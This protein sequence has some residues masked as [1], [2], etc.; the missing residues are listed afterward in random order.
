MARE[1]AADTDP[2]PE[3]EIHGSGLFFGSVGLLA[4]VAAIACASVGQV[5]FATIAAGYAGWSGFRLWI[6]PARVRVTTEGIVDE[7]FWYSP[8]LIRW[9][10]I[11]DVRETRWPRVD[12]VLGVGG[13]SV[14]HRGRASGRP[15]HVRVDILHGSRGPRTSLATRHRMRALPAGAEHRHGR[16]LRVDKSEDGT[17]LMAPFLHVRTAGVRPISARCG[18]PG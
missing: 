3:C 11:I 18:I 2:F 15:G 8:G 6:R 7:M 16:G 4:A 12:R 5:F 10:E 1:S 13:S 17:A 9:S 14:G